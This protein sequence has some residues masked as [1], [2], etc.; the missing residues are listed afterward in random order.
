MGH[1]FAISRF[2]T[3]HRGY[4]CEKCLAEQLNLSVDDIR[5]SLGHRKLADVA[6]RYTVCQECLSEKSVVGLRRSA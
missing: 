3:T 4:Y 1:D 2:L 5:W 6:L